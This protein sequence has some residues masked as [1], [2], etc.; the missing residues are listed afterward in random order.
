MVSY[1][2]LANFTDQGIRTIKNSPQRAGQVAEMA[3][4]FGCEMKEI[5]WTLGEYDIVTV[6]NAADEQSFT[7]FGFALGSLGN[8]RTQTLRA[9]TKDEISSIIGRLS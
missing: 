5:Y 9:F 2:V 6:I 1:V 7:A 8:V 4:T 3:K